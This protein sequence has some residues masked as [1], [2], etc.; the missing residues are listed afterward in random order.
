MYFSVNNIKNI[1]CCIYPPLTGGMMATSSPGFTVPVEMS[2][3]SKLTAT[4]TDERIFFSFSLECRDSKIWNKSWIESDSDD[5]GKGMF[6]VLI[7]VA[8]LADAKYRTFNVYP[9][10]EQWVMGTLEGP[11]IFRFT[12]CSQRGSKWWQGRNKFRLQPDICA[13]IT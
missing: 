1:Y 3:Y 10:L 7:P 12:G 11:D 9:E 2:T 13:D 4:A 5:P 8:S 6:S